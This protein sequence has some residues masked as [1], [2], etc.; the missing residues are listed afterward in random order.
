MLDSGFDVAPDAA[1]AG[2]FNTPCFQS[3]GGKVDFGEIVVP[4]R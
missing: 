3:A 1:V 4:A 2:F